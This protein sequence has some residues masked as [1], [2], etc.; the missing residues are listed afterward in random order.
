MANH[1]TPGATHVPPDGGRTVWFLGETYTVKVPGEATG[2]A[3]ALFEGL[4]PPGLGTPPHI[5]HPNDETFYVLGGE[6][7]DYPKSNGICRAEGR[8]GRPGGI[9]A[10]G[11]GC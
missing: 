11:P 1:D 9:D 2:G 3:F 8:M 5:H 7:D 10:A 6:G 4:V